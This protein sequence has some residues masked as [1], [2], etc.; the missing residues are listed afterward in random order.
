MFASVERAMWYLVL[1]KRV[2]SDDER[3]ARTPAHRDWLDDQHRSGR[4]LFSGPS[5]DG[6][7]GIYVLLADDLEAARKLAGED[8]YHAHGDR[9]A[10]VIEWRAHRS[11]RLDGI[12]IDDIE[13]AARGEKRLTLSS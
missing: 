2:K 9:E 13:S 7:Y 10:N 3:D 12:T 5:T 11:L 4:L 6:I 8:P 1:S